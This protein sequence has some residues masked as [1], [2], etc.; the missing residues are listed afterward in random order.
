MHGV[1]LAYDGSFEGLLTAAQVCVQERLSPIGISRSG[2][3]S[4]DLFSETRKVVTDERTSGHVWQM[5]VQRIGRDGAITFTH[6]HLQAL[7]SLDLLLL[8]QISRVIRDEPAAQDPRDRVVLELHR[9]KKRISHEVH[10]MHAFVRFQE[11]DDGIWTALIAP[12]YDVL[13]LIVPHFRA[14]FADMRWMIFDERRGY[15]IYFDGTAMRWMEPVA[16]EPDSGLPANVLADP[17]PTEDAYRTLW[18]TYYHH[19]DIPGRRNLKLRM[20]HMAKRHW[21]HLVELNEHKAG[22]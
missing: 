12:A 17:A 14:R 7:P 4:G 18:R 1:E 13:P 8:E 5:L 9:W 21:R 16:E 20:R 19:V 11:N 6:C 15:G 10:H 3:S 22:G 2:R